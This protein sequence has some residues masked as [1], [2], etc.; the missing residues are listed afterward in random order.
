[1]PGNRPLLRFAARAMP[2]RHSWLSAPRAGGARLTE[3]GPYLPFTGS[4]D[5]AA[6]PVKPAIR[7]T[8]TIEDRGTAAMRDGADG[9]TVHT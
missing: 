7:L 4:L 2:Q 1:M 6:G 3:P 9:R 8:Y 5:V